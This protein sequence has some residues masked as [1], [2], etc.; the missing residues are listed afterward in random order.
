MK[1]TDINVGYEIEIEASVKTEKLKFKTHVSKVLP[2]GICIE[3]IRY[4]DKLV[5]FEGIPIS[6]WLYREDEKPVLWK[7]CVITNISFKSTTYQ[8]VMCKQEGIQFNRR[9]AYR[10]YIGERGEAQ[11]GAG[12]VPVDVTVKDVSETGFSIV[13]DNKFPNVDMLRV[14]LTFTDDW[15]DS[16][17]SLW[18]TIVRHV[19]LENNRVL[20]GCQMSDTPSNVVRFINRKQRE[21]LAKQRLKERDNR[22]K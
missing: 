16:V 15:T 5:S 14:R 21:M 12:T 7:Q 18:G 13:T 11:V 3:P 19:E 9:G 17:L 8:F 22:F 10:V 20:I 1:I 4:Q 2:N 6:I